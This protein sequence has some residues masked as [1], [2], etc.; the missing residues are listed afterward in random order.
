MNII[1]G[2][3]VDLIFPFP[4]KEYHRIFS[5]FHCYRT[6]V[7]S[8]NFPKTPEEFAAKLAHLPN[9]R[10]YGIID[11]NNIIGM[12]HEAPLIGMYMFDQDTVLNGNAHVASTRKAWGSRLVDQ[13]GHILVGHVFD[14]IPELTRVTVSVLASNAPAK[15]LAKRLGFTYEGRIR[16]AMTVRDVPQDMVLFGLTRRDWVEKDIKSMVIE[17]VLLPKKELTHG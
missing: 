7:D 4:P 2:R 12:R 17:P 8:T 10:T 3:D 9:V 14:S 1:Q 15:A 6:I 16:D 11:K 5:W 13:A